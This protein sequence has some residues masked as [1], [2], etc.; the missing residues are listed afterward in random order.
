F[1]E[2]IVKLKRKLGPLSGKRVGVLGLTYK[3]G[4]S[5]VRRS[6]ALKIMD[7]L[8]AAGA[9]CVGYDPKASA[10]ELRAIGHAFTRAKSVRE[11]AKGADAL[12]LVTE[13]PEFRELPFAALAKLMKRPFL[14]D[15]K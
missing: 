14:V 15:S 7:L 10:E 1:D 4:T 12:V 8:V 11:L 3:A 13:W 6:P 5:T 2:I 9:A